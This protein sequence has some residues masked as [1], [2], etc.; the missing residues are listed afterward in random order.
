MA[1]AVLILVS[2]CTAADQATSAEHVATPT[3]EG[4][5]ELKRTITSL[6]DDGLIIGEDRYAE[7]EESLN[8]FAQQGVDGAEVADLRAKL[9]TLLPPASA[10]L[11]DTGQETTSLVA[12]QQE[13][14]GIIAAGS[15]VGPDHY[16]RM[17]ADVAALEAAG[18][19]PVLVADLRAKLETLDPALYDSQAPPPKSD[20]DAATLAAL[21]DCDGQ[22]F[23]VA[24]VDLNQIMEITPI[25]NL[26]PPGHTF[27][28]DHMY[29]HL[30]AQGVTTA[31]VPLKAPG[32]ITLLSI[33]ADPDDIAPDR[34]EYV[35]IFALCRDV[36]GYFDHVKGLTAQLEAWLDG[37]ACESYTEGPQDS[38]TKQLAQEVAAGTV[39][40]EVGHLQGNFD[41]GAY[42]YRS[43]LAFA[44]SSRYGGPGPFIGLWRP[45]SLYIVCPLDLYDDP[46]RSQLLQKV[47]G[48]NSPKCGKT[49]YDVP[50][51]LQGNWFAGDAR[52]D[53]GPTSALLSFVYENENPSQAVISIGGTIAD[54]MVISF[55]PQ[56]SGTVNRRFNQVTPGEVYCYSGASGKVIVQLTSAQEA[57][58][59]YRAG[60]CAAGEAF[61]APTI[62]RR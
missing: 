30:T 48:T 10:P 55:S 6:V 3:N 45:R 32:D 28:T 4:F 54:P 16:A 25:G 62:Y 50:G 11:D 20:P 44:N 24:P 8:Q 58:V 51:T 22:Q 34:T 13:I 37:V 59:E 61:S 38:C 36:F 2:G 39:I 60:N 23:T 19:D 57:N 41:F 35:I 5:D 43:Q 15:L 1:L 40:G 56:T 52:A 42:D 14:D 7:F 29:L 17:Q 27:P 26:G 9:A 21:P 18:E 53:I 49:L 12:L 46:L 31:T 33:T 47:A